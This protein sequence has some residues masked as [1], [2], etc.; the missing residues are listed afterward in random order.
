MTDEE[1]AK[2]IK[3]LADGLALAMEAA[4]QDGL[5]LEVSIPHTS[6]MTHGRMIKKY[7]YYAATS[8]TRVINL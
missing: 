8:V 6:T 1:H 7:G 2:N 3:T 4:G 5:H